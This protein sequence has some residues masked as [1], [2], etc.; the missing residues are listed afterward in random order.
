MFGPLAMPAAHAGA[1]GLQ[2]GVWA[3]TGGAPAPPTV[4]AGGLWVQ[5]TPNGPTAISAMRFT[6]S[7]GDSLPAVVL[8]VAQ[9]N[10]P[11]STPA[12]Q[13]T[14]PI[15]ACAVQGSWQPTDPATPG[16][17]S[18]A[19]AYD[20]SKGQAA[21]T[22]SPDNTKYVFDVAAFAD[23]NGTVQFVLVPGRT[24]NPTTAATAAS[25]VPPPANALAPVPAPP[26][27]APAVADPTAPTSWSSFDATF[28]PPA[29]GDISV[30]AIA[31]A[32]ATS[33]GDALASTTA[34][35]AGTT[36]T[37]PATPT[38][39]LPVPV[40]ASAPAAVLPT[41]VVATPAAKPPV[42][43]SLAGRQLQP[44][45]ALTDPTSKS[46]RALTGLVFVA[47]CAWAWQLMTRHGALGP[48]GLLSLY[49]MPERGPLAVSRRRFGTQ[50]RTG[51]PPSLR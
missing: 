27:P 45:A 19:P 44:V 3:A 5:S 46:A 15:L 28:A 7:P 18:A 6:L 34:P 47:L 9:F 36:D 30:L 26:A 38:A 39:V 31:E 32:P 16:A 41:V 8:H 21:G 51:Q 10:A 12:A 40:A 4:P 17:L 23:A 25:P 2:I 37:E 33:P 22:P 11:P 43:R 49:D 14:T 48:N 29:V 20:C 42:R 13:V 1:S 35:A 50:A 24:P